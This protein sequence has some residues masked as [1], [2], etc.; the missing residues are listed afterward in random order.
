[1]WIVETF[2]RRKMTM[3]VVLS[4]GS[5]GGGGIFREV[6]QAWCLCEMAHAIVQKQSKSVPRGISGGILARI[7]RE[8]DCIESRTTPQ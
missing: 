2:P 5:T 8:T 6:V 4:R 3:S 1:M 7:T